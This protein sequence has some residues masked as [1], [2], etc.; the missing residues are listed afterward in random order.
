VKGQY[1]HIYCADILHN[2][3]PIVDREC[4][5][6]SRKTI[7]ID[8]IDSIHRN[9]VGELANDDINT[10]TRALVHGDCNTVT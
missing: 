9:Y 10:I 2:M 7:M 6:M 1:D 3:Y 8:I 5:S 4:D